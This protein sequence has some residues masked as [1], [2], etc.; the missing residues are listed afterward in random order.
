MS[1]S[2]ALRLQGVWLWLHTECSIDNHIQTATISCSS[3]FSPSTIKAALSLCWPTGRPAPLT[4]CAEKVLSGQSW[5]M[6]F[7]YL[8]PW[9]HFFFFLLLLLFPSAAIDDSLRSAVIHFRPFSLPQI[10][11]V[12]L[13]GEIDKLPRAA[14]LLMAAGTLS[15]TR[16]ASVNAAQ[17]RWHKLQWLKQGLQRGPTTF[18]FFFLIKDS[19]WL[20]QHANTQDY[21]CASIDAPLR[22]RL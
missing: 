4:G 17:P 11:P 10:H 20:I 2:W 13:T 5:Q 6:G 3:Y 18:V 22:H 19:C 7:P 9:D 14:C 12:S 21:F 8:W 16:A 15:R 1:H